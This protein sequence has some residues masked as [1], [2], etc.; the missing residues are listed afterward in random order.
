ML[1]VDPTNLSVYE[2]DPSTVTTLASPPSMPFEKFETTARSSFCSIFLAAKFPDCRVGMETLCFVELKHGNGWVWA[3]RIR[4]LLAGEMPIE[5]YTFGEEFLFLW[6]VP[7]AINAYLNFKD[8]ARRRQDAGEA[9][10]AFYHT[11]KAHP[12]S[13]G[14]VPNK[15]MTRS[16][17]IAIVREIRAQDMTV[18]QR[19]F[20]GSLSPQSTPFATRMPGDKWCDSLSLKDKS[21]LDSFLLCGART[22]RARARRVAAARA[23]PVKRQFRVTMEL[24]D[25][26]IERIASMHLSEHM[27]RTDTLFSAVT[28]LRSVCRQ[29]RDATEAC[30]I[31]MLSGVGRVARSLLTDDPHEPAY[32]QAVVSASG[33]T[34]RYALGLPAEVNWGAYV[35]A[36]R[37]LELRTKRVPH[38]LYQ[39]S[40]SERFALLWT[41]A[42]G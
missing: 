41:E 30:I 17:D 22:G 24:P 40:P 10:L 28:Q 36:R 35:A 11:V 25:D 1:L 37:S 39:H 21:H 23:R 12:P 7:M 18:A 31:Q 19:L 27:G 5:A 16:T 32:V 34:L 6:P 29:F 9:Q 14:F 13:M 2:I 3:S 8:K 38:P 33:L 42:A 26:L 4:V 20:L 15:R